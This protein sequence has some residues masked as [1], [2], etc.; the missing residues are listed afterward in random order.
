ML[1]QPKYSTSK[2]LIVEAQRWGDWILIDTLITYNNKI[3][4]I[5]GLPL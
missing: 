3:Y 1:V 2:V 5:V 4:V